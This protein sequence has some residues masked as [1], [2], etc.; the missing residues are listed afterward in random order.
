MPEDHYCYLL[1]ENGKWWNNRCDKN[2]RGIDTQVFVRRGQVGPKEAKKLL[3]Y[4]KLPI[5]EIRGQADFLTRVTGTPEAL[6]NRHGPE[7]VF[8]TRDQYDAFVAGKSTVS[9][10]RFTNLQELKTPIKWKD[11]AAGLGIKTM[12]NGGRYL[13]KE[14]VTFIARAEL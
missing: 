14:K 1:V 7:T 3:F 12:P 10:I 8:E 5:G 2:Q 13:T 6:W 4:V 11:L 9:V